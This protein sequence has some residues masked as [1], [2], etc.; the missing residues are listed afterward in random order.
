MNDSEIKFIKINGGTALLYGKYRYHRH[1]TYTDGSLLWR[2]SS[3]KKK[4]CCGNVTIGKVGSFLVL[5]SL[6]LV[7]ER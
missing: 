5:D 7:V 1:K 3:Y 2:C 4:K 6:F